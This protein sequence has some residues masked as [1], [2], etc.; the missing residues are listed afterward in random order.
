[1]FKFI[2]LFAG[3]GGFRLAMEAAGGECVFTSEWDQACQKTYATNFRPD[4]EIAGDIR[5][6]EDRLDD[7]PAHD[8]LVAG[9]PCQPLSIAGVSKKN[10]LNRPHGFQCDIQGTLFFNIAQIIDH[11]RPAAFL[12]ENVYRYRLHRKDQPGKPDIV[13][14]KYRAV[15]LVHGCFWHRHGCRLTTTPGTRRDFWLTKF[16]EN[17]RRDRQN[18]QTLKILGWRVM[19]VWECALKGKTAYPE[20]VFDQISA[21]LS[22]D[23]DFDES[24]RP[25]EC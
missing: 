25:A 18:L 2:D 3:I 5:E 23:V 17:V 11:H 12:L 7:I 13:L 21:F 4:H 24:R 1:M 16:R 6:F 20:V 22:S 19:V 10:A 15:I 9:F 14:P 8:V